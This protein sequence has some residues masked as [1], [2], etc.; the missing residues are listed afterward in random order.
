[1]SLIYEHLS[2]ARVPSKAPLL[3]VSVRNDIIFRNELIV[4]IVL[5]HYLIL[6]SQKL[7]KVFE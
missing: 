6:T 3:W 5:L 1:M 4:L 2:I 7:N